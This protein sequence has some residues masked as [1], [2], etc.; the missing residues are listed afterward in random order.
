MKV[1]IITP[2]HNG[3]PS[4]K[5]C[6]G[7]V[8]GQHG[9]EKEHIIQDAI[10][11]DGTSEWLR[12]QTD[13]HTFTEADN[14][15][16]DAIN[17]GWARA[18][19]DIIC[20]LN[21]DEQH[22]PGAY[23]HVARVFHEHEDVDAIFGDTIIVDGA[24]RPLAARREIPLRRFY[25]V[26]GFLYSLSCSLFFRRGLLDEGALRFDTHY[27]FAGDADLMIR[28]LDAG[29]KVLHIDRYLGLFGVDGTNLSL[30][31]NMEAE[32]EQLRVRHGGLPSVLCRFAMCCRY[33]ERMLSG[34][35]A[36]QTISYNFSTD[37]TP[38]Y[39]YIEDV[40]IGYLFSYDRFCSQAS[41]ATRD[42]A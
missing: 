22:L 37:E 32:K 12:S 10:S 39:H 26:N 14:G 24:G 35:Y 6:I 7:S 18:T 17:R 9:L 41:R 15:M 33:F 11:C 2:V 31:P 23:E 30:N 4:L 42:T 13:L 29:K 5:R 21:H 8:R 36:R 38:H 19:G 28:L 27:R 20:W 16:Y 34:C 3:M 40:R 1:S 25:V